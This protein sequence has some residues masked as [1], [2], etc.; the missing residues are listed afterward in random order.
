MNPS[1]FS[2]CLYNHHHHQ[3]IIS[4]SNRRRGSKKIINTHK[5]ETELSYEQKDPLIMVF[6]MC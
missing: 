3:N 2:Y 4:F 5:K 6:E 1:Q